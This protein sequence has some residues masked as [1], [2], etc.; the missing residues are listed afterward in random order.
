MVLMGFYILRFPV[1]RDN[2]QHVP[3]KNKLAP[4]GIGGR[5]LLTANFKVT[6]HKI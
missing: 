5:L 1:K 4:Y 3:E 2:Q 6:L